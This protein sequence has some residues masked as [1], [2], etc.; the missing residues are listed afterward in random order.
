METSNM[1]NPTASPGPAVST[2]YLS[3]P[4]AAELIRRKGLIQ[5]MAGIAANIR[6]D[7]RQWALAGQDVFV[8]KAF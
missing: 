4:E 1:M 7:F 6:E 8:N 2:L 5:C 3:A